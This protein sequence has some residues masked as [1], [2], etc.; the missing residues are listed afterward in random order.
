MFF[1]VARRNDSNQTK[2]TTMN[3][4]N[5]LIRLKKF[6]SQ[7]GVE[8]S[9]TSKQA[10]FYLPERSAF[11]IK[12]EFL[13]ELANEVGWEIKSSDDGLAHSVSIA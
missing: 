5:Q 11:F 4:I 6:A 7:W 12:D 13:Q 3:T 10:C 8:F 2:P 9:F 1:S